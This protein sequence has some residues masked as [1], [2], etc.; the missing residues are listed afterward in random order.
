MLAIWP[1]QAEVSK[2]YVAQIT[3]ESISSIFFIFNDIEWE[4]LQVP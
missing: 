4:T 3:Y 1:G 2:V